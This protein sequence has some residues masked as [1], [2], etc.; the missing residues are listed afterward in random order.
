MHVHIAAM[1][2]VP[3]LE[4]LPARE[5]PD[6]EAATVRVWDPFV[7]LFHWSLVAAIG[8]ALATSLLLPPTWV[9]LH[10]I[11]G[12]AAVALVAARIVWGFFGPS[13]A[14]FASFVRGPAALTAHLQSLL[15]G[16]AGHHIG[17]NPLGGAMIVVLFVAILILGATG[18]IALGGVFKSGPAAFLAS[19]AV[20]DAARV[21]HQLVAF[22]L[23]GLVALHLGGVAFESARGREN[24]AAAMVHG[25]K[26]EH[27][28]TIAEPPR[29]ARPFLAVAIA[30]LVFLASGVVVVALSQRPALGVPTASLD[31]V[32]VSECGDCHAPYH[33]SLAP[34]AVWT[35]IMDHLDQHFGE[36]ASLEPDA[37]ARIRAYL[38]ANAAETVDTKPAHLFLR[39]DPADPLKITATPWWRRLHASIADSVFT[40]KVVGSRANCS[41]CHQDAATGLFNPANIAIPKDAK[42]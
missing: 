36:D 39:R 5:M 6:G 20:G 24:L 19:F 35:A 4:A 17:H 33:P 27:A 13:Y 26:R 11:S 9:T 29:A 32:Y 21:L 1:G 2:D 42:L 40:A 3:R 34:A 7:R 16:K 37:V 8:V 38:V 10:I 22:G 30:M 12:T 23:I 15:A 41:A 18:V 31:A 28:D 14:R 25:R